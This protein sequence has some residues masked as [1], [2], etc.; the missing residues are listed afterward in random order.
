MVD[1]FVGEECDPQKI[2]K[3][4]II[5]ILRYHENARL[6]NGNICMMGKYHN[7]LYVALKLCYDWQLKDTATVEALLDHIYSCEKTF[8]RLM[9][10]ALFGTRAPHF[11]AGWKSDFDSQEEN[12]RAVVYYLDNASNSNGEY[13]FEN[14]PIRFVDVPIESCG[15]STVLKISI[16]LGL[17]DKLHIF[18]RFGALILPYFDNSDENVIDIILDKLSEHKRKYPYNFVACLQLLLRVLPSLPVTSNSEYILGSNVQRS[19]FLDKYSFLVEDAILPMNRCGILPPNL[20]HLCRCVV[21]DVL[22]KNFQ[23]PNGIKTLPIPEQLR[24]Y[25]DIME[26]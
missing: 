26:D 16:Q 24:R 10:G 18:L 21:R 3:E 4:A 15:K 11:I 13:L 7:V 22:W 8:E 2:V 20:K 1:L 25:I 19:Y 5:C 9:V 12:L 14:Y 17:P 23:L 6:T